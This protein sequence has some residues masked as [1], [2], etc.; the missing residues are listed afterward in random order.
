MFCLLDRRRKNLA[1]R[2]AGLSVTATGMPFSSMTFTTTET[3]SITPVSVVLLM[4]IVASNA[5]RS[6]VSSCLIS[7]LTRAQTVSCARAGCGANPAMHSS[8]TQ[9]KSQAKPLPVGRASSDGGCRAIAMFIVQSLA[10]A[11]SSASNGSLQASQSRIQPSRNC[12]NLY[13]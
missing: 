4:F 5:W 7:I 1:D 10:V 13:S 8:S 11:S 6:S 9:D 2:S 3:F 12:L